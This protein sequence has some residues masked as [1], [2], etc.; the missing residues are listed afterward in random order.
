ML[1]VVVVH[2]RANVDVASAT[3]CSAGTGANCS[4]KW[5][6][7]VTVEYPNDSMRR[8]RSTH[9]ARSAPVESC[10]PKRNG[11]VEVWAMSCHRS[12]GCSR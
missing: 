4:V 10:T 6:G 9:D 2:E 7:I 3:H 11:R 1:V 8:A 12:V 5:S